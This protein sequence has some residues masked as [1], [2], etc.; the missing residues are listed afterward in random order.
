MSGI[1]GKQVEFYD[2]RFYRGIV[3]G[4]WEGHE[5]WVWVSWGRPEKFRGIHRVGDLVCV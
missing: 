4:D 1:D 3:V 2:D 5:G